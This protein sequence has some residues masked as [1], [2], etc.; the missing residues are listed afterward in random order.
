MTKF[1]TINGRKSC[2]GVADVLENYETSKKG[3]NELE[4]KNTSDSQYSHSQTWR[5]GVENPNLLKENLIS[6][7]KL[8][9]REYSLSVDPVANTCKD[10]F[11]GPLKKK[12]KL[13]NTNSSKE[14]C[15]VEKISTE[16]ETKVAVGVAKSCQ[17]VTSNG[18][19]LENELELGIDCNVA[20]GSNSSKKL[21]ASILPPVD[22]NDDNNGEITDS[23]SIPDD[24]LVGCDVQS[25]DSCDLT[26]PVDRDIDDESDSDSSVFENG[27]A[28]GG[29]GCKVFKRASN[30]GAGN[31]CNF[32]KVESESS[33][34][35]SSLFFENDLWKDPCKNM[36][37]TKLP[38]N[39][40]S[41]N[42]FLDS[43]FKGSISEDLLKSVGA[44][45]NHKLT[46]SRCFI[47]ACFE[48][49]VVGTSGCHEYLQCDRP[50]NPYP[51]FSCCKSSSSINCEICVPFQR[52]AFENK[53]PH[54]SL[55]SK[56]ATLDKIL[57][58]SFTPSFTGLRQVYEN[59]IS[60]SHL[61]AIAFLKCCVKSIKSVKSK[62]KCSKQQSL[63]IFFHLK[64]LTLFL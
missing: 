33:L 32:R 48:A 61:E 64:S 5:H 11:D 46:K 31:P 58:N 42:I 38:G 24:E 47:A 29:A 16:I 40:K 19:V 12:S 17:G 27:D 6:G 7:K 18:V 49:P 22:E 50:G 26:Y 37:A 59:S 62:E 15:S 4:N 51:Q 8:S 54:A 30:V 2:L 57:S 60:K 41:C 36:R 20:S 25:E 14:K 9:K 13:T 55:R 52:W 28:G 56:G 63:D 43:L 39:L 21:E 53:V 1:K 34:F 44:S 45:K 35:N 23:S 10:I 3:F